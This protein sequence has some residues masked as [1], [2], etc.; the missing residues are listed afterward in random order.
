MTQKVIK[1]IIVITSSLLT[2]SLLIGCAYLYNKLFYA[3]PLEQALSK[4][5]T[6]GSFQVNG[7]DSSKIKAQ[8]TADEKLRS[9]FYTLLDRLEGQ[10]YDP[11]ALTIEISN[12]EDAKLREFLT[13]AMLPIFEAISTGKFSE[14]PSY[15]DSIIA[16][17]SIQYSLEMDSSFIFLTV[18][19]DSKY[20]HMIINRGESPLNIVNTMGGEYL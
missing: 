18:Q 9:N 7:N 12:T 6:I 11:K 13:Q 10:K 20:A 14:L 1:I 8:F 16:N 19:T 4:I 3:D 15:L 17:T 2:L 5:A